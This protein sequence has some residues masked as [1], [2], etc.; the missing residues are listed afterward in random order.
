[1]RRAFLVVTLSFALCGFAA[2]VKRGDVFRTALMTLMCPT[3]PLGALYAPDLTWKEWVAT[4]RAIAFDSVGNL[5]SADDSTLDVFDSTL[6]KVRSVALPEPA[7]SLAVNDAGIT[8]V[9]GESGTVYVYSPGGML[10]YRFT[11]PNLE[12]PA[13]QVSIDVAP[14]GCTL[15]YAGAGG[16]VNR[17]DSC[18]QIALAPVAT[19][20]HFTAIRAM[21][22][23][24]FAGATDSRLKFYNGSG[25]V[26][27]DIALPRERFS[28]R[29]TQ[30]AAIAFDTNPDF[31]YLAANDGLRKLNLRD[32]SMP[33]IAAITSPFSVAVFGEQRPTPSSF[34][35]PPAHRRGSRH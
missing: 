6:R 26:V 25:Q 7:S 24:G 15:V 4:G 11:L 17:F 29:L 5:Y 22:E 19:D 32:L 21:R 2:D 14:E 31:I 10:Q 20:E 27:F 8:Y 9:V 12:L 35:L 34:S 28:P 23:G 3:P 30:V 16:S 18:A 13:R 33:D 1:M